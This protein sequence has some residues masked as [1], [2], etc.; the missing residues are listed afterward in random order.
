MLLYSE[1]K[2]EASENSSIPK[3][4]S[5][6]FIGAKHSKFDSTELKEEKNV[7]NPHMVSEEKEADD[8]DF[9]IFKCV[10]LHLTVLPAKALRCLS[11]KI[12]LLTIIPA[13]T[14]HII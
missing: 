12:N 3:S 11:G 7:I 5:F 10:S 6:R 9:A 8:I 4:V 14:E 2:N 13:I 1:D